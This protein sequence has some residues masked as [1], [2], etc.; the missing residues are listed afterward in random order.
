[1]KFSLLLCLC[2]LAASP[3]WGQDTLEVSLSEIVKMAQGGAPDARIAETAVRND[4]W[5]YQSFLADYKPQIGLTATLPNLN[6]SIQPITLP[7]GSDAFIDRALMSN[8]LG[9]RLDQDIALTGGSVF[10]TTQLERI[11]VFA[12]SSNPRSISY[13]STPFAIGFNQ[14]LFSFNRLRWNKVIEPLRYEEAQRSYSENMEDVAY[15]AA[16]LFFNVLIAQLN[17][18]AARRDKRYADTLLAISEGRYEVGRIAETELLQIELNAMNADADLASSSLNLQ[19]SVEQL[20]NFLGIKQATFFQPITPDELP[21]FDIKADKALELARRHRSETV[22]F[23]RRL[24]EAERNVAEAKGNTGPFVNITGY[25]GLSQTAN[26]FDDAYVDPLDQERINIS[27]D[28]PIADWGKD[29]SERKIAQSNRE[30]TQLQVEQNRINFEREILVKVQQFGLQRNRV[31]L[32]FRAYTVA[33]KQ[34]SISRKR[35]RIGK[36]DVTDLNQSIDAEARAR[37]SYVNALRNFWL[38]YYDLR[39]ITL[40]DF[41]NQQSLQRGVPA[42]Q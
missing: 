41:E 12:T 40:F 26:D 13:L 25:F 5:R 3:S 10:V 28:V 19:T 42:E 17:L 30:L 15:R 6:R 1:M 35:Y 7:D 21:V 37:N 31:E 22:A 27:L 39:R 23:E 32:A 29:R 38:A 34:L 18:K 9:L 36:I 20:R 11:D 14:P 33:Q 8:A 16:E 24:K 2:L 4:Y